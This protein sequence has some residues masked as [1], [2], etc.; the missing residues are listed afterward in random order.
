LIYKKPNS[1]EKKM[2]NLNNRFYSLNEKLENL[3]ID[4]RMAELKG[5]RISLDALAELKKSQHEFDIN[6]SFG[7]YPVL[8]KLEGELSYNEEVESV[9]IQKRLLWI[10]NGLQ[11]TQQV[12]VCDAGVVYAETRHGEI[13]EHSKFG[14]CG[15]D[16]DDV[17]KF[18]ASLDISIKQEGTKDIY[19]SLRDK[20]SV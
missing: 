14:L 10:E 8:C 7:V 6:K 5:K 19:L 20:F 1:K 2:E 18:I 16:I 11:S 4:L 12:T 3:A 17:I 13:Y 15:V 9:T